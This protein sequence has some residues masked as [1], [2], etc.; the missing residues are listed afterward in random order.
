[1]TQLYLQN[2]MRV[3]LF[4]FVLLPNS[5]FALLNGSTSLYGL[6]ELSP[7][8]GFLQIPTAGVPISTTP[9]RPTLAELGINNLGRDAPFFQI[10]LRQDWSAFRLYGDYEYNHLTPSTVLKENLQTHFFFIGAGTLV[11]TNICFDLFRLGINRKIIYWNNRSSFALGAEI[12]AFNFHYQ[13]INPSHVQGRNLFHTTGCASANIEQ[14][15]TSFMTL[16]LSAT[17]SIPEATDLQTQRLAADIYLNILNTRKITTKLILG[18][19]YQRITFE[20]NQQMPNHI[21]IKMGPI[22]RIGLMTSF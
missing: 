7:I 4:S 18:V 17:S 6:Y 14:V 8:S 1:M 15:I 13:F 9:K 21:V 12:N 19:G 10:G 22:T 5:C 11:E 16:N 3:L 20:D 2:T